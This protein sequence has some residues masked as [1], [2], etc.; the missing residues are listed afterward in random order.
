MRKMNQ[1]LVDDFY[2]QEIPPL[3]KRPARGSGFLQLE[4]NGRRY[5][6]CHNASGKPKL[7]GR[8]ASKFQKVS[9]KYHAPYIPSHYLPYK[10]RQALEAL[11]AP[12]ERSFTYEVN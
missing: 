7:M 2:D 9:G 10:E 5:L 6:I 4:N 8:F 11:L 3:F 12:Y 1:L